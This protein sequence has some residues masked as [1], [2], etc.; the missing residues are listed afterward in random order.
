MKKNNN[1]DIL[2]NK[3]MIFFLAE[4]NYLTLNQL[5]LFH[6]NKLNLLNLLELKK[7][8]KYILLKKI[9]NKKNNINIE[10]DIIFFEGQ[11]KILF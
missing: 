3:N 9:F 5:Y 8:E 10:E 4:K 11:E 1:K 6:E 2:A 7:I